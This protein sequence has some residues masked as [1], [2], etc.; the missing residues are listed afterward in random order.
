MLAF[1]LQNESAGPPLALEG[2]LRGEATLAVMGP[3][4]AG[5]SSLL[6]ALAGLLEPERGRVALGEDTWLDTARGV[7]V[8]PERRGVGFVFQGYALFPRM[9]ARDNVAYGIAGGTRR[10]RRARASE[11]LERL[12]VGAHADARP[13]RL[14]GGERQRVAL[15]R[16]LGR[17]PRLL[18]LDE[19]LSALD[20]RTR[21]GAAAEL[22]AVLAATPA[23]A[24]IV[25]HSF[26]EAAVLGAEI[27]VLDGGRLIQRGTA[28]QL[29]AE[30][31]SGL[32]G[33]LAG[34]SVLE[35]EAAGGRDGL[36]LV[37]LA[38]GGSLLS[39]D[40]RRGPVA[41]SVFP[42][43]VTLS[44]APA[45]GESAMNHL[46]GEIASVTE[47]GNRARVAVLT[48]QPLVAEIT[49]A[50]VDRLRLC[51]GERVTASFKATATRLSARPE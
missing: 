9:S 26:E 46:A 29:A 39:T 41:V 11:L 16:A 24:I 47:F 17:D 13:G 10:E 18:L 2:E 12:G 43:E 19:P 1:E 23:P 20:P 34:A 6:R 21:A 37:T 33:D 7:A 14:S 28:A 50:S 4:G 48:P 32:V 25:T 3:S 42:W 51:P 31:V 27:A 22:A 5:K 44:A 30:P 38:G 45:Q 36:T 15:A 35:G 8:R 40:P 49:A